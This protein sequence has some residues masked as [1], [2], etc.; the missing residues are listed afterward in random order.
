MQEAAHLDV[1]WIVVNDDRGLEDALCQ[2]A[3][4]L[5]GEI[6][7]PLHLHHITPTHSSVIILPLCLL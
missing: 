1:F 5:A 6:N 4:V 7:A 3:L 2:I